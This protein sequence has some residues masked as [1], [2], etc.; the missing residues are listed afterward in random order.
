M[1]RIK[2][3]ESQLEAL[4]IKDLLEGEGIPHLIRSYHDSAYDG[5]FQT[6]YGWGVL[7]AEEEYQEKIEKVLDGIK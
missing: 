3:I 4:R 6:Q 7:L 2:V 5:V 1:K